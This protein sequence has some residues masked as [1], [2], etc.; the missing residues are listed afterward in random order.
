MG[1]VGIKSSFMHLNT[2]IRALPPA[3]A[4]N[5]RVDHP[6]HETPLPQGEF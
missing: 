4:S 2:P 1:N 5:G 6:A 3:S